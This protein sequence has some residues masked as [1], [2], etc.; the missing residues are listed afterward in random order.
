[1][2][3]HPISQKPG[4]LNS[5]LVP[6]RKLFLTSQDAIAMAVNQSRPQLTKPGRISIT[7][8]SF[9]HAFR[10]GSVT[11]GCGESAAWPIPCQMV[12][13]V[14]EYQLQSCK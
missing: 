13:A 6:G 10:H 11:R 8:T 7:V 12:L 3:S 9:G 14:Q 4:E 2:L 5:E 1:L